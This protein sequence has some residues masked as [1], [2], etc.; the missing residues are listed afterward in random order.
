LI[1]CSVLVCCDDVLGSRTGDDDLDSAST[2]PQVPM[3][4]SISSR[5]SPLLF[6]GGQLLQLFLEFFGSIH[7]LCLSR[8]QLQLHQLFFSTYYGVRVQNNQTNVRN[9]GNTS[10]KSQEKL[11]EEQMTDRVDNHDDDSSEIGV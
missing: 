11:N 1:F 6:S 9:N 3:Y 4:K 8:I 2:G 7:R 5:T 10:S